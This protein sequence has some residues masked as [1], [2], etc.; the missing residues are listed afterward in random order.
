MKKAPTAA[1]PEHKP[2]EA[3]NPQHGHNASLIAERPV[4]SPLLYGTA[5]PGVKARRAAIRA[6]A[7]STLCTGAKGAKNRTNMSNLRA[8]RF[9]A[10]Q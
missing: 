1:R 2:V 10:V 8:L 4:R 9:F 7:T 6:Y 5:P 3:I